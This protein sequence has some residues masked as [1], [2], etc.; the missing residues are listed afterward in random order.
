MVCF[1]PRELLCLN[2]SPVKLVMIV[3]LTSL[4]GVSCSSIGN[5]IFH[6][7]IFSFNVDVGFFITADV[8]VSDGVFGNEGGK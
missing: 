8:D 3:E 6:K 7:S 2:L 1:V 4:I 5:S